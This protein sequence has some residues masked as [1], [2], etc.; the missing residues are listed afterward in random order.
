MRRDG[1]EEWYVPHIFSSLP[2][3]L[4]LALVLFLIGLAEFLLVNA[5]LQVSAPIIAVMQLP[6]I[7]I[8]LTTI[9]PSF[10]W[11]LPPTIFVK[12]RGIPAQC[13]Y[14]SPQ[15]FL[16]RRILSPIISLPVFYIARLLTPHDK[17]QDTIIIL[18]KSLLS[19]FPHDPHRRWSDMIAL[20]Y[21]EICHEELYIKKKK[22][23]LPNLNSCFRD[24]FIKPPERR[25]YVPALYDLIGGLKNADRTG[26]R[27]L[28]VQAACYQCVQD[29]VTLSNQKVFNCDEEGHRYIQSML[30]KDWPHCEPHFSLEFF[31]TRTS[32][33]RPEAC[34]DNDLAAL[35]DETRISAL[36]TFNWDVYARYLHG[37][38]LH[39]R[40]M[41]YYLDNMGLKITLNK[42]TRDRLLH[43]WRNSSPVINNTGENDVLYSE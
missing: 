27:D 5:P 28:P 24:P 42:R 32:S 10:E 4:L 41:H 17:F 14:K 6:I 40:L 2:V 26:G 11:I 19:T 34:R 35:V 13:P 15:S 25:T 39:I 33:V 12:I 20:Y 30:Q 23:Q 21:R 8:I 38:E 1:L 31:I 36:R 3:L 7:F 43:F 29:L 18:W 22:A 16:L 37:H 9:F